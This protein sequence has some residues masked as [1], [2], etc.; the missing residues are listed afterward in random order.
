MSRIDLSA[1]LEAAQPAALSAFHAPDDT[2]SSWWINTEEMAREVLAAAAPVIESAV[3]EQIARDIETA[4]S[5][6]TDVEYRQGL[7]AAG[8]IVRGEP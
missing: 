7:R 5:E 8:R 1:A 3:R 6:P 2:H 4:W